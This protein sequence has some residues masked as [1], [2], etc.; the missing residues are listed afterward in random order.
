MQAAEENIAGNGR[1]SKDWFKTSEIKLNQAIGLRNH[2]WATML[3][4]PEAREQYIEA[5]SNLKR[6]IKRATVKWYED[7]AEEICEMNFDPK[8]A[9]KAIKE[10]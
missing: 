10:N 1:S 8:N 6:K 9:W 7:R 3:S 2:Q 5:Q 4:I